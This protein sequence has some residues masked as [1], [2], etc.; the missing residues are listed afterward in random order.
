MSHEK[1]KSNDQINVVVSVVGKTRSQEL[2][3]RD[4]RALA[5]RYLRQLRIGMDDTELFTLRCT[6]LPDQSGRSIPMEIISPTV[7]TVEVVLHTSADQS[8][9]QFALDNRQPV[10]ESEYQTSTIIKN[11]LFDAV[12]QTQVDT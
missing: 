1:Q 12:V 4:N 5:I 2:I 6:T 9:L 3:A 8:P 7:D 10:S 11:A